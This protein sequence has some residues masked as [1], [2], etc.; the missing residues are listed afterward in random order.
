MQKFMNMDVKKLVIANETRFVPPSK[1][2]PNGESDI[3]DVVELKPTPLSKLESMDLRDT[4]VY[5][6]PNPPHDLESEIFYVYLE[7]CP[8]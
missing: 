7:T 1:V 2:G 6:Y 5:L 8:L 3:M 4:T